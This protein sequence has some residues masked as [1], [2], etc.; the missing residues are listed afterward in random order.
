MMYSLILRLC[1]LAS[2]PCPDGLAPFD[3]LK[4]ALMLRLHNGS[5]GIAA[6]QQLHVD[7]ANTYVGATGL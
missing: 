6:M 5:F 1:A 7:R 4:M 3:E 2:A